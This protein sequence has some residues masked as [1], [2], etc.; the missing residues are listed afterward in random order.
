MCKI[1]HHRVMIA[2]V[3]PVSSILTINDSQV[4]VLR[5]LKIRKPTR[6]I[7]LTLL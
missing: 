5:T 7:H 3:E 6:D 1:E 4:E 2:R